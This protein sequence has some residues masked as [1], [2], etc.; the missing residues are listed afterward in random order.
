MWKITTNVID[1]KRIFGV[2]RIIDAAEIDHSGNREVL[3]YYDTREDAEM[4]AM[5]L[6]KEVK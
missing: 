4:V 3:R 2:Y 6:N 1:G 5:E